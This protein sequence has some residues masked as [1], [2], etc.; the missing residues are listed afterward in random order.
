VL[1]IIP[2]RGNN[3]NFKRGPC[4]ENRLK[5][6][7]L[8]FSILAPSFLSD[9]STAFTHLKC[10]IISWDWYYSDLNFILHRFRVNWSDD[11]FIRFKK[12][13]FKIH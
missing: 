1:G 12:Q 3:F 10:E 8:Y 2:I 4:A 6:K 13:G 9:L 5:K 7:G 11:L